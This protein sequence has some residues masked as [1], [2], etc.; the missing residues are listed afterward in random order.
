MD[1]IIQYPGG[2]EFA[3]DQPFGAVAGSSGHMPG[4]TWVSGME[5]ALQNPHGALTECA[6]S[7]TSAV[8]ALLIEDWHRIQ[9]AAIAQLDAGGLQGWADLVTGG[10]YAFRRDPFPGEIA[11]L[12]ARARELNVTLGEP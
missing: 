3:G 4:V 7:E 12:L 9:L 1:T 6:T 11:A 8:G 10:K 5:P 2:E